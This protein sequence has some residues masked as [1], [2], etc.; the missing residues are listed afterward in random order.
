MSYELIAV[1]GDIPL[2]QLGD[3]TDYSGAERALVEDI[4]QIL[5]ANEGWR[6]RVEHQIIGPGRDGPRT[7][8]RACAELGTHRA[9]SVVPEPVDVDEVRCWLHGHGVTA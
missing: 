9:D 7:I 1:D 3:F 5:T 2:R 4:L 6:V 8:H